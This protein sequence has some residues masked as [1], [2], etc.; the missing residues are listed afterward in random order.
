M[1]PVVA[2]AKPAVAAAKAAAA[3]PVVAAAAKADPNDPVVLTCGDEKVTKS[4][5]E[6]FIAGLPEQLRTQLANAPK[7]QVAQDYANLR[8][9]TSE[10][11][12]RKLD[13]TGEYRLQAS[14]LLIQAL[15]K[16]LE[17]SVSV[18]DA[19]VQKYYDEH[20]NE[21]EQVK[22]RHV[23][24]RFTGSPAPAREGR[25]ELTKEQALAKAQEVKKQIEGGA[26]FAEVAKKE[27]DDGGSGANGGDLGSFGRG[28]MVPAFDQTV[29]SL[30]VGKL[31]EPVETQFG[32]HIIQVQERQS[33]DFASMKDQI[34]A[35]LKPQTVRKQM[36]E[37][38]TSPKVTFDDAYFGAATPAMPPPVPPAPPAPPKP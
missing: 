33:K 14:N 3:K 37:I 35:Q 4:E 34:A 13:Q 5:F 29:F 16:D 8:I 20:K 27:S 7:R 1:K 31:S 38:R 15:A 2:A 32:Y 9:L 36:E 18:T 11:K 23:L 10:A 19:D 17:K 6:G 30:P 21:Y 26:D 28:Q 12:R 22:A 24:I 25:G